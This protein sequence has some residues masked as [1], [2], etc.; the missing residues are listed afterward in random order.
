MNSVKEIDIKNCTYYFLND[1]INMKY[2]DP[3]KI[4]T[5]IKSYKHFLIYDTGYVVTNSVKPFYLIVT[6]NKWVIMK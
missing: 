3:S 4:K 5:D 2:L 1:L 6:I